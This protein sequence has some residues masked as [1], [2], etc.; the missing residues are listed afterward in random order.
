MGSTRFPGKPLAPLL[1]RPLVEHVY[2][3]AVACRLLDEVVIATCDPEIR[4]VAERFGAR[5]AMTSPAHQRASERVA[6]AA[7]SLEGEI[8]VM[9]QGDE[10]LIVPELVDRGVSQLAADPDILC[11]NLC[12]PIET[13]EEWLDPN[14]IKVVWSAAGDALYYSRQPIPWAGG[15][16]FT[17]GAWWKQVCVIPFRKAA[18]QR[19]AELVP[20]PLE[21]AESIDMLRFLEHG[22]PVRLVP[23]GPGTRAVDTL[24]D[25]PLVEALL[26]SDPFTWTYLGCA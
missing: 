4:E 5:V 7:E 14:T 21:M 6:E 19:F 22:V 17:R 2:R 18:L 10:P 1:G 13:L 16:P 25:L 8:V 24:A 20:G 12:A 26:A 3:R 23:V 9:I 15:E 11:T